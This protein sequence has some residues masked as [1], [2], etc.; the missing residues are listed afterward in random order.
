MTFSNF[1]NLFPISFT[2]DYNE[3]ANNNQPKKWSPEPILKN[4]A[5]SEKPY[6]YDIN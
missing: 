5:Y 6:E 1:I 3:L 4:G 2:S